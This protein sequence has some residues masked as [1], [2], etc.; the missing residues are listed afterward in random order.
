MSQTHDSG[1]AKTILIYLERFLPAS[2]AFVLTQAANFSR[3]RAEFLA[4]SRAG[5]VH[6]DQSAAFQVNDIRSKPLMRA[7]ETV[8]KIAQLPVPAVFSPLK[9]ASLIHAH[10][11]KNGYVIGPLAKAAHLPLVTSFHGFD[12]TYQGDPK[13]PGGFNQVRFFDHGRKEMAGWNSWNIAVSDFIKDKLLALG[14]PQDRIFRHYIGV[15]NRFFAPSTR[16]RRPGLVVSIARFMEYKGHRYMIEALSRVV[17]QGIPVEF[18]MVG[19]G[20]LRDEMEALARAKLPKVTIYDQLDQA[21][22]RDLVSE[23]EIYLHGSVTLDNGHAEAMG[24]ANLEAQ[25]VGTPVVAFRSG[26]VGEAVEDGKTGYLAEE[27]DVVA[28]AA[29]IASLLSDKPR[30]QAFSERAPAMVAEKFD[31]RRQT[32]ALEDYYDAVIAEYAQ[33]RKRA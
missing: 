22:I 9:R 20:P 33:T 19:Q 21:Q 29:G 8:L 26:G 4:G 17:A 24:I 2:Q 7:G 15:D 5:S 11:G 12:A 18:A 31:I 30:W 13:T 16:P 10:F 28:M 23:A 1:A 6:A 27:R 32:A 3:H 25:A 14:Y